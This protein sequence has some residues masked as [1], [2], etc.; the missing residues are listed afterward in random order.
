MTKHIQR[1]VESAKLI[2]RARKLDLAAR[3]W[4]G[5]RGLLLRRATARATAAASSPAASTDERLGS[6]GGDTASV[7]DIGNGRWCG[8]VLMFC[9]P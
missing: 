5:L 2:V 1:D 7:G 8:G 3:E 4:V 6:G 9:L